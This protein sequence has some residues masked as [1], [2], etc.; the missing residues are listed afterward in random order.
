MTTDPDDDVIIWTALSAGAEL[1]I[2]DDKDIVPAHARGSRLYEHGD[3]S[4]LAVRFGHL[5]EN[6]LDGVD[7][8]QI[9]G[10]M[11]PQLYRAGAPDEDER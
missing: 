9:D 11:L 5:V 10:T 8:A 4:V 2:S 3:N 6:Q 7:W 1:L